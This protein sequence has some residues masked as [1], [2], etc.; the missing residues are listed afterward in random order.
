VIVVGLG[1]CIFGDTLEEDG[2]I[3]AGVGLGRLVKLF[4]ILII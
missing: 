3:F 4:H 2:D 1:S